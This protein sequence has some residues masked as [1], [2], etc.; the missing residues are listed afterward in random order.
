MQNNPS[1]KSG[2]FERWLNV[3]RLELQLFWQRP[4]LPFA[5][6]ARSIF[7]R[8]FRAQFNTLF[9]QLLRL[10]AQADKRAT[11][12][13][14]DAIE[15]IMTR[16]LKLKTAQK[17]DFL[18]TIRVSTVSRAE[19]RGTLLELCELRGVGHRVG[20]VLVD[21][22]IAIALGDDRIAEA[23]WLIIEEVLEHFGF[24]LPFYESRKSRYLEL[25]TAERKLF[26]AYEALGHLPL[27]EQRRRRA[28][29]NAR[30]RATAGSGETRRPAEPSP[31][32][33][34]DAALMEALAILGVAASATD[35]QIKSA[36]RKLVRTYHPDTLKSTASAATRERYTERFRK[37]HEA[38]E[39][40]VERRARSVS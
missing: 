5:I 27:A 21:S 25:R 22:L 12:G 4:R 8:R 18:Q 40:I 31:T 3:A 38:Y 15:W 32:F 28:A 14:L 26:D 9:A 36:Y 19:L 13:E 1:M 6:V 11:S 10:I 23:E 33:G 16:V 7:Q 2:D 24:D 35:E 20:I 30:A 39:L 29:A 37:I 34:V 17:R